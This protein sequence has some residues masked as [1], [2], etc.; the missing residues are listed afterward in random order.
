MAVERIDTEA[1][2]A[3]V[4]EQMKKLRD[5]PGQTGRIVKS[6]S[7]VLSRAER[8]QERLQAAR[9]AAVKPQ[10]PGREG[11]SRCR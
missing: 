6:A 9:D 8:L 4:T 2:V 1:L 10:P 7:R 3:L 11:V 5:H